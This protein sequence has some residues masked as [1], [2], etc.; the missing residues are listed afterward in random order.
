MARGSKP[1]KEQLEA[2]EWTA[3][4]RVVTEYSVRYFDNTERRA[5]RITKGKE[6]FELVVRCNGEERFRRSFVLLP[7]P[8]GKV[9]PHDEEG[10]RKMAESARAYLSF[11]EEE[12]GNAARRIG[13][14]AWIASHRDEDEYSKYLKESPKQVRAD[15]QRR[16]GGAFGPRKKGNRKRYEAR[17]HVGRAK[18]KAVRPGLAV[19]LAEAYLSYRPVLQRGWER[20]LAGKSEK[21]V[22][23]DIEK[24]F[25]KLAPGVQGAI[26]E[27]VERS[28]VRRPKP[29][30]PQGVI[31]KAVAE[32]LDVDYSE[33][34]LRTILEE[35]MKS[36]EERYS[37]WE[38][39]GESF[40]NLIKGEQVNREDD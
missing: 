23:I 28:K 9:T 12:A 7:P 36:L 38:A 11:L 16:M 2:R 30:V 17:R 20:L 32:V 31:F 3:T 21:A 19:S 27:M 24:W 8:P 4:G 39:E 5:G 33:R 18:H 26:G 10:V 22:R 35:G 15:I 6:E 29:D 37:H 1:I 40:Y 25:G 34:Q 14:E 13:E